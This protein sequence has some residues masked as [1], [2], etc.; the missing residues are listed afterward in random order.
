MNDYLC[1]LVSDRPQTWSIDW[2]WGISLV[3]VT[4]VIHVLG[5][6]LIRRKALNASSHTIRQHPTSVFVGVVGLTT[7]LATCL[8]GLEAGV[9][10]AAYR[11]LG[12][13]ADKRSAMLYSLN[14]M[15]SYGHTNL[16]LDDHWHLLGAMEALNGWLL[17]GLSTAFLFA[18]I[19]RVSS[20]RAR[21]ER[22][23]D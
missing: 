16:T 10:A 11:F 22:L 3:L 19:E 9:W 15:T 12:V 17:F 21:R 1:I 7:L 20:V 14:A 8:H 4:V 23:V 2:A 13:F 6:G 18:V 5:L